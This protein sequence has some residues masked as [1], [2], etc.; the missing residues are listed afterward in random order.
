MTDGLGSARRPMSLHGLGPDV[1]LLTAIDQAL[2]VPEDELAS[3][4]GFNS[5]WRCV[6]PVFKKA[7]QILRKPSTQQFLIFLGANPMLGGRAKVFVKIFRESILSRRRAQFGRKRKWG[8]EI[9]F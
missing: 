6:P 2:D 4:V 8:R 5:R 1:A 7:V 3:R 9:L